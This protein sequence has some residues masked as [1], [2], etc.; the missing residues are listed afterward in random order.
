MSSFGPDFSGHATRERLADRERQASRLRL[1]V[2]SRRE[3][4]NWHR[5]PHLLA[6]IVGWV[7][8]FAAAIVGRAGRLRDPDP[9]ARTRAPEGERS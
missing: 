5:P 6:Q 7:H 8:S 1:G 2:E 4:E 9:V 3:R